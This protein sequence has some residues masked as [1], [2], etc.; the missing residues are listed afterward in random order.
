MTRNKRHQETWLAIGQSNMALEADFVE[1]VKNRYLGLT[2]NQRNF[3]YRIGG[4]RKEMPE[5]QWSKI[6][7]LHSF[8][9]LPGLF[10]M[11]HGYKTSIIVAAEGS[12]SI[13][14][15]APGGRC[16]AH[17]AKN[18]PTE[19]IDGIIFW[20]GE[21]DAMNGNHDYYNA[22]VKLFED[23]LTRF[24]RIPIIVITLQPAIPET[25]YQ[26]LKYYLNPFDQWDTNWERIR[27]DQVK[28]SLCFDTIVAI[29]GRWS[30]RL[31]HPPLGDKIGLVR[32]MV[33]VSRRMANHI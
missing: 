4:F 3:V 26:K 1:I 21:T 15:W 19:K 18:M 2:R 6:D 22:M 11:L 23:L 5:I 20:Q 12:T 25:I 13:N 27:I 7:S 17:M 8:P 16:H 32:Q 29:E 24:G 28:A 33:D 30:T 10:C 31:I 14:D 9:A